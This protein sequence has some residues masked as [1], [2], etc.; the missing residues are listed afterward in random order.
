MTMRKIAFTIFVVARLLV[1]QQPV[2]PTPAQVGSPRGENW[3]NYNIT[4]SFETGYRFAEVTGNQGQYASQVNYG[5]G[6]RLLGSSLTVNSKDGHGKYFDDIVLTTIGLG[7]DPYESARLRIGKNNLYDYNL[8]WRL[9]DYYNPAL[10]VAFGDH[11]MNTRRTMQDQDL[12]LFPRAFVQ[13]H[14]GYSN[15]GQS[16]PALTTLQTFDTRSGIFPLFANVRRSF[17]EYRLGADLNFAGFKLTILHRWEYLKDDTP[18]TLGASITNPFDSTMLSSLYRAEPTHGSSPSWLGN[19]ITVRKWWSVNGRFVY[20]SG[21]NNF[22][23]DELSTG[24]DRL[25]QNINRQTIISGDAH[26]PFSTGDL[27]LSLFPGDRLTLVNN[28]SFYNQRIDG[29]SQFLEFNLGSNTANAV[30][31]GYL[32]IRTFANAT[33][34]HYKLY[35][36]LSVYAG[37]H[38]STRRIQT[39]AGFALPGS[40]PEQTFAE[41]FNH[42]NVGAAGFLVKP[43]KPVSIMVDVE[44]G[45]NSQPYAPLVDKDY[46]AITARVQYKVSK[47]LLSGQYLQKYNNNAVT[48]SS[49]SSRSR[50][51]MANASW[52]PHDWFSF[53]ASYS[54][55]HLDTV[56]GIAFFIANPRPTLVQGLD[57]IYISNIHAGTLNARFV[58]RKR[59]DL[60]VGYSIIKD[61]GD[62]RNS[63]VPFPTT[64][65]LQQLFVSVQTFPLSFQSPMARVSV[66]ISPKVRWNVG[67]QYYNY[68]EQFG[69]F[70]NYQYY[71]ANTGYTSILWSF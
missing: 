22:V 3:E 8:L 21:K 13:I 15:V 64:D 69:L 65:P 56:G 11:L 17:N 30:N 1:A 20:T 47:L 37:Y 52:V 27:S 53:D 39:I 9:N 29:N 59:V 23:Q 51:Y 26:R 18:L 55:L 67:W 70:A 31:F 42:Q 6:I 38:Y 40:G 66:R 57:S 45:R 34:L 46:H 19:L 28:T 43:I 58:I 14:A 33:D 12:T 35:K 71:H 63:A 41:Q 44:I 32:G 48:I 36:W 61:T 7:N 62:G 16:G 50:N 5:N 60:Y 2:A 4:N 68:H 10:N 25:G 49:Y 54:K 24:L